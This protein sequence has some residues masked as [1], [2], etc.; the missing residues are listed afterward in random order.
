MLTEF[1]A[2]G[3]D[4]CSKGLVGMAMNLGSLQAHRYWRS[5]WRNPTI[6]LI[7][8]R[9]PKRTDPALE[10]ERNFVLWESMQ[11][12]GIWPPAMRSAGSFPQILNRR[13][14]ANIDRW[15]DWQLVS[16]GLALR[17]LFIPAPSEPAKFGER[18]RRLRQP[19]R[20]PPPCFWMP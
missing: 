12:C 5:L 19:P 1:G 11:S 14:R 2:R 6:H 4:Q 18:K 7:E 8:P 3:L 13:E 17:A 16:L 10:D 20:M 9:I 15:L